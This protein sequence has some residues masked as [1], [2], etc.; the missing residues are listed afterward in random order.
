MAVSLGRYRPAAIPPLG[1]PQRL[2]IASSSLGFFAN[3][4]QVNNTASEVLYEGSN[5]Y[6]LWGKLAGGHAEIYASIGGEDILSL[7]PA[8]SAGATTIPRTGWDNDFVV[9]EAIITSL[10]ITTTTPQTFTYNASAPSISFSN[11]QS[12]S[13]DNFGFNPPLVSSVGTR[14]TTISLNQ[15]ADYVATNSPSVSYTINKKNVTIALTSQSSTYAP[16]QG[17]SASAPVAITS[18]SGADT[19]SNSFASLLTGVPATGANAGSYTISFN[20][21]HTSTNYNITN[22]P[23]SVTWTISKAS[24]AITFNP[25]LNGTNGQTQNLS[26]YSS[27]GLSVSLSVVSGPATLNGSTL[28]YTGTGNVVVRA[29]QAGN[30]NYNPASDVDRTISVAAAG[31]GGS[32]I[33][34]ASTNTIIMSG[35]GPTYISVFGSGDADGS[36]IKQSGTSYALDGDRS[37]Y[38]SSGDSC[39]IATWN[40]G[41]NSYDW[42]SAPQSSA[43][44]IPTNWGGGIT[45]AASSIP[46]SQTNISLTGFSYTPNSNADLPVNLTSQSLTLAKQSNTEWSI[47]DADPSNPTGYDVYVAYSGGQWI[48]LIYMN[49]PSVNEYAATNQAANTSIPVTGWVLEA[50]AGN[51]GSVTIT[52]PTFPNVATTSIVNALINTSDATTTSY[53]QSVGFTAVGG[54]FSIPLTK[55]VPPSENY[56]S[57]E[58]KT[59]F[60][61]G[62]ICYLIH[63]TAANN[64]WFFVLQKFA[65][66]DEEFGNQYDTL[67]S[68]S[69]TIGQSNATIPA[70][71]SS[72][73]TGTNINFMVSPNC[74]S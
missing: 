13:S 36:Y 34:V 29:S 27:S 35:S 62:A 14:T 26:A 52:A 66:Y 39:W 67:I 37:L 28:T 47:D 68:I 2:R 25:S 46:L 70:A 3:L 4:L 19:I 44:F 6:L 16:N 32:G 59:T 38:Y 8:W 74:F 11:N 40:N 1:F 24:Q 17:Y 20:P 61:D 9:S 56:Y 7:Y 55:Q 21:N 48:I 73:T 51:S 41:D 30:T 5:C 33:P 54:M 71:R 43:S 72:Y 63:S 57:V 23:A 31:G 49:D 45:I 64:R 50:G 22:S 42:A 15:S 65:S 69:T 18:L 60:N 53:L 12:L 58:Y 10:T